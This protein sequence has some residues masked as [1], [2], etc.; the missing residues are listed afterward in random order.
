MLVV[1]ALPGG[2][3]SIRSDR[4][5]RQDDTRTL[6]RAFIETHI[7]AGAGILVQPYSVPL[8]MSRPALEEAL[9]TTWAARRQLR[10]GFSSSCR[11]AVPI[12]GLPA[13][14]LGS[15]GLD[16]DKRLR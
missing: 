4:F 5:F 3:A 6:A 16:V 15:G 13:S 9:A 2:L 12:A 1:A 8:T 14:Y 10:P 7:P 11:S